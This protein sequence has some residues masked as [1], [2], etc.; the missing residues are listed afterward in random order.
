[1]EERHTRLVVRASHIRLEH[2]ATRPQRALV[3][4]H[5][6][7]PPVLTHRVGPAQSDG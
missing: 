4:V 7:G 3:T 6:G 5:V 2:M 1:M